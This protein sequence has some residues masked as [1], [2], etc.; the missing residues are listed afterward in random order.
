MNFL[1]FLLNC[2][3]YLYSNGYFCVRE[4]SFDHHRIALVGFGSGWNI[5]SAAAHNAIVATRSVVL[6]P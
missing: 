5:S 4:N 1:W 2:G 3:T 6:Y